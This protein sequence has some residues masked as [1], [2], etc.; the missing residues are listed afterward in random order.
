MSVARMEARR[1]HEREQVPEPHVHP[2]PDVPARRATDD[3][4]AAGGRTFLPVIRKAEAAGWRVVP[5]YA[6]GW[7]EY[8]KLVKAESGHVTEGAKAKGHFEVAMGRCETIALRM[9]RSGG[10][11]RA[12]AVYKRGVDGSKWAFELAYSWGRDHPIS[13]RGTRDLIAY[14]IRPPVDQVLESAA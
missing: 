9:S 13:R 2:A 8:R 7:A 12:V 1:R 14:L 4:L 6:V 3:E 5:T 11:E 10:A